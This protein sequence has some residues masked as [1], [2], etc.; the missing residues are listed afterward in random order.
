[1]SDAQQKY[2]RMQSKLEKAMK[3]VALVHVLQS[4]HPEPVSVEEAMKV[5]TDGYNRNAAQTD[6]SQY[7]QHRSRHQ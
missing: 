4:Q 2:A 3:P 6:A 5:I 7:F 1:L